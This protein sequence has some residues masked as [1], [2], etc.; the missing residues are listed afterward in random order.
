MRDLG[1]PAHSKKFID[2]ILQTFPENSWIIVI[3]LDNRPVA[4]GLLLQHKDKMDIPL[5]ST[6]RDVNPLGI[7]MLMYWEILKFATDR[8]CTQFDFGR[9][10]K[11][12]G[13]YRFKK[14]WGAEPKQLY[15]HYWL[16]KDNTDT[17]E[18]AMNIAS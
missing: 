4:A 18:L 13:T 16:N 15:I 11:D 17:P 8:K 1:S 14:Q 2:N 7:N 10:S 6:I 5:A 9:S 12:S 3:H